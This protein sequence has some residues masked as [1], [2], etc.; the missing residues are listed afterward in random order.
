MSICGAT[1]TPVLDF[2]WCLLWVS[3]PEWVLP[4]SHLAEAYVIYIPWD[5]LLVRHLLPV[6]TANIAASCLPHMRVSAEVGCRDFNCRPPARQSDA[7]PTRPRRP[8]WWFTL[9][10]ISIIA[11]LN[12]SW[13]CS[14]LGELQVLQFSMAPT[15]KWCNSKQRYPGT[16]I[17][18][19]G[20]TSSITLSTNDM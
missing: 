19:T 15:L 6:Y 5:S 4:Y 3:K 14:S 9:L 11:G 10:L 20:R 12:R 18:D 1:D 2:W 7:L 13:R 16:S 17:Y 8:A